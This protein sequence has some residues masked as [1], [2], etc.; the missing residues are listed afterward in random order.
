MKMKKIVAGMVA[1][2]MAASIMSIGASAATLD[3]TDASGKYY[4]Y[5]ANVSSGSDRYAS[6]QAYNYTGGTRCVGAG[7]KQRVTADGSDLTNTFGT[8]VIASGNCKSNS[9][10]CAKANSPHYS[11]H[12][13]EWYN[14]SVYESGIACDQ[15]LRIHVIY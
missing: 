2:V 15:E 13:A 3:W 11:I 10:Y 9:N 5:C 8:G 7:V 1:G 4:M 6:T 14:S 12:V